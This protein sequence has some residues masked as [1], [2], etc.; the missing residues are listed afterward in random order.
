MLLKLLKLH[1]VTAEKYFSLHSPQEEIPRL[2]LAQRPSQGFL[3]W[4]IYSTYF[5]TFDKHSG[6]T[7]PQ[8]TSKPTPCP[9]T[10]VQGYKPRRTQGGRREGK[11]KKK[12]KDN[13]DMQICVFPRMNS[14]QSPGDI[15]SLSRL[16]PDTWRDFKVPTT[17]LMGLLLYFILQSV[18]VWCN[19][20][21]HLRLQWL[22][23][24]YAHYV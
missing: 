10:A 14:S 4:P 22:K 18:K 20:T 12:K 1:C 6:D 9:S 19:Q 3:V 7:W 2:C 17:S 24:K 11:K 13:L 21:Y 16:N 15:I 23:E 8:S 5:C